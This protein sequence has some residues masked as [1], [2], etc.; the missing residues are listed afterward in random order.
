MQRQCPDA[1]SETVTTVAPFKLHNEFDQLELVKR[2]V[3]I[4]SSNLFSAL[5]VYFAV[6]S[7]NGESGLEL[8]NDEEDGLPPI[9]AVSCRRSFDECR[10]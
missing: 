7:E 2:A 1:R 6:S 8:A 10:P 4:R 9:A 3:E 5:F